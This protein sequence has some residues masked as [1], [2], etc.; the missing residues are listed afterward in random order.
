MTSTIS[1]KWQGPAM[2]RLRP[3]NVHLPPCRDTKPEHYLLPWGSLIPTDPA[4]QMMD[5]KHA[6]ETS[7]DRAGVQCRRHNLRH[8]LRDAIGRERGLRIRHV[9]ANGP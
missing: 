1:P 8:H 9:G 6:W 3:R 7:R 4:R 5:I 2:A